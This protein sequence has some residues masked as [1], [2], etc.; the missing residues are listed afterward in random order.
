MKTI[1]V[2]TIWILVIV[3]EVKC[4]IKVLKCDWE[5]IGK[6]EVIYGV[7]LITGFGAIVGYIDIEDSSDKKK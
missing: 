5:P 7:S 3:G 2:I 6:T 1:L 4:F